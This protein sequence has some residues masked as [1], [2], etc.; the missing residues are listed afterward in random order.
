MPTWSPGLIPCAM[1]WFA[2]RLP[3]SSRERRVWR[4]LPATRHTRSGP[5]SVSAS[6]RSARLYVGCEV[7][8]AG[9]P[10]R[11]L[12]SCAMADIDLTK[13]ESLKAIDMFAGLDEIGLWHLSSLATIATVPAGTVLLQPGE[14]GQ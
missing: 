1:R 2:M 5:A 13:S 10:R 14:E 3:A 4:M 7:P 12:S 11:R 9:H 8:I 6:Q